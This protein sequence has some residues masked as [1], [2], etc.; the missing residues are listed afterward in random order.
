MKKASSR[1][2]DVSDMVSAVVAFAKDMRNVGR[3]MRAVEKSL[4]ESLSEHTD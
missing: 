1:I 4:D 2:D 3:Y